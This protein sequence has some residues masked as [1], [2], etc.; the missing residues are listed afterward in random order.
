MKKLSQWV[1]S[2]GNEWGVK[3][4]YVGVDKNGKELVV[5]H[6]ITFIEGVYKQ[7]IQAGVAYFQAFSDL[8]KEN[9]PKFE[10]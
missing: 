4:P 10:Y 3:I 8:L 2:D 6:S 5:S 7:Q 1:T 9:L